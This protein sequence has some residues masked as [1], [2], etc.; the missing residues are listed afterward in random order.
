MQNCHGKAVCLRDLIW[1]YSIPQTTHLV[2]Y[3]VCEYNGL[4]PLP[5]MVLAWLMRHELGGRMWGNV[6]GS[7]GLRRK[8]T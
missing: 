1:G 7:Y 8:L 2:M 3:V 4:K 6:L 5:K